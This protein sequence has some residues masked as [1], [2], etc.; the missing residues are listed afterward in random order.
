MIYE[1]EVKK[2]VLFYQVKEKGKKKSGLMESMIE[3]KRRGTEY[4]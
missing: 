4:G 1:R 3:Q 2:F